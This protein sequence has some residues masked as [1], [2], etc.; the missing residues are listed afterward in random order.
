MTEN[1]IVTGA[2]T[3]I[4]RAVAHKLSSRKINVLVADIN[5]T[6]GEA[7]AEDLK[8]LY[9]VDAVFV[10]TDVSLEED[11]VNMLRTA[12]DRWGRIDYACNN[13]GVAEKMEPDEDSVTVEQFDKQVLH[14]Y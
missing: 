13:A 3:G 7:V 12:V 14:L 1:A 8:N 5:I 10:K 9:S 6:D 11:V 4:G 2:A